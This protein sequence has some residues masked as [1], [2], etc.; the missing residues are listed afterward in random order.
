MLFRSDVFEK[1]GKFAI[2]DVIEERFATGEVVVDGH[3]RDADGFGDAAHAHGL[4]TFVFEDGKGG[5]LDAVAGGGF[6]HRYT[7]Y[8]IPLYGV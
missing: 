6:G 4:R 2:G 5:L 7:V 3:G 1:F 8:S